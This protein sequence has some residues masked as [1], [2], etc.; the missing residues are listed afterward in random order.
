MFMI[1]AN[2][3]LDSSENQSL[4]AVPFREPLRHPVGHALQLLV[5]QRVVLNA[6]PNLAVVHGSENQLFG[7]LQNVGRA[8]YPERTAVKPMRVDHG[9]AYILVAE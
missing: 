6:I 1:I 9:A 3:L 8:S 5:L 4:P 7:W 2:F